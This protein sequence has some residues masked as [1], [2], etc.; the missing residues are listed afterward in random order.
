L[1]TIHAITR[2]VKD[3]AIG[4]CAAVALYILKTSAWYIQISLENASFLSEISQVSYC[5][6][7]SNP[8]PQFFLYT[9]VPNAPLSVD[10]N[11]TLLAALLRHWDDIFKG[12][13][14]FLFNEGRSPCVTL[15][16][17]FGICHFVE[18]NKLIMV[19]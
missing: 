2:F 18:L 3:I 11:R 4:D 10:E 14:L 19:T 16:F 17:E 5:W 8:N 1:Y 12:T 9:Y 15:H 7:L 6:E 13:A